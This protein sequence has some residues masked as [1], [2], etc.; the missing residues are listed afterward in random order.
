MLRRVSLKYIRDGIRQ[1]Y[2]T[3]LTAIYNAAYGAPEISPDDLERYAYSAG[4]YGL[5]G[6]LFRHRG[7]GELY[8]IAG[9]SS[10]LTYYC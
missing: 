10:T 5:N 1:G 3:D 4:Q 7:T 9:R 6:A 2:Y 8:A